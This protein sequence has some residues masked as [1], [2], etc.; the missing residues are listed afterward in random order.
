MWIDS[1]RFEIDL[2]GT[3]LDVEG[4]NPV[5]CGLKPDYFASVEGALE[6]VYSR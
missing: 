1:N 3:G 4:T 6:I 2:I 5:Q